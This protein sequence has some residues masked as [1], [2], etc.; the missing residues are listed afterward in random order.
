[1][2]IRVQKVEVIKNMD[3]GRKKQELCHEYDINE[4]SIHAIYSN[5]VQA[6]LMAKVLEKNMSSSNN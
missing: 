6:L 2:M 4:S 5:K 1:M 3:S